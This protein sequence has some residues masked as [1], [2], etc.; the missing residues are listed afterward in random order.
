MTP[1]F[2]GDVFCAC[3][4][5]T[6]VADSIITD[7][8]TMKMINST[9]KISVS[10]VMLI[11]QNIVPPPEGALMAIGFLPLHGGVDQAG[12][13]DMDRG[14]N[15]LHFLREIIVE[16]HRDNRDGESERS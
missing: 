11:S 6:W 9:R 1:L 10:G 2:S 8:V 3:G 15:P 12:C 14:V 13:A 7:A 5:S 16:N 4:S